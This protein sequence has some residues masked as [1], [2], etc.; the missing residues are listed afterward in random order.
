MHLKQF[1]DADN[2]QIILRNNPKNKIIN[3]SNISEETAGL[4]PG[5]LRCWVKSKDMIF[6]MAEKNKIFIMTD[7]SDEKIVK[8]IIRL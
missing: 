8:E 1:F 5:K 4:I 6:S 3:N 2:W 7:K